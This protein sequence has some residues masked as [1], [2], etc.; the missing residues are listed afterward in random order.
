MSAVSPEQ[1]YA[2]GRALFQTTDFVE[3]YAGELL[4]YGA[5]ALPEGGSTAGNLAQRTTPKKK[6]GKGKSG[7]GDGG[8]STEMLPDPSGLL[9]LVDL[10][11]AIA[12][13]DA[14]DKPPP[15]PTLQPRL[16][17]TAGAGLTRAEASDAAADGIDGLRFVWG[18]FEVLKV[19]GV[20]ADPDLDAILAMLRR[21]RAGASAASPGAV[22]AIGLFGDRDRRSGPQDGWLAAMA[23]TVQAMAAVC[24][25]DRFGEAAALARELAIA[26]PRRADVLWACDGM[27]AAAEY[28]LDD[29]F[30]TDDGST[31]M[32]SLAEREILAEALR[33]AT[34]SPWGSVRRAALS[35]L[36][37]LPQPDF[38]PPKTTSVD[39]AIQG[40]TGPCDIVQRCLAVERVP[41]NLERSRDRRLEL[42]KLD[43]E[44]YCSQM[45]A[46]LEELPIRFLL[47]GFT[48][49]FTTLWTDVRRL[50]AVHAK[51]NPAMFWRLVIEWVRDVGQRLV[52]KFDAAGGGGTNSGAVPVLLDELSE[53]FYS[54][55]VAPADQD[56]VDFAKLHTVLF[57][58]L[59]DT[60][61][62]TEQHNRDII[63]L[64]LDFM[65]G[66]YN[67]VFEGFSES[68]DLT[69]PIETGVE[70]DPND[71]GS[72][73]AS[74]DDDDGSDD[75]D[76]AATEGAPGEKKQQKSIDN[77]GGQTVVRPCDGDGAVAMDSQPL[78]AGG[79][80]SAGLSKSERKLAAS[81][82]RKTVVGQLRDFLLLLSHF[83]NPA[84]VFRSTELEAVLRSMLM[85]SDQKS[86]VQLLALK[87]LLLYRHKYLTPY[88]DALQ[89][90]V[91]E[92]GN[93]REHLLTFSLDKDKGTGTVAPE[94]REP[95][96][97]VLSRIMIGKMMARKGKGKGQNNP[98]ARRRLILRFYSDCG[99]DELAAFFGLLFAPFRD[100]LDT[101][102][103]A[104]EAADITNAVPV[105]KQLGFL[106]LVV[107]IVSNLGTALEAYLPRV[108]AMALRCIHDADHM[109]A[110]RNLIAPSHVSVLR[111]IRLLGT[112]RVTDI[113]KSFPAFDFSRFQ[114]RVPPDVGF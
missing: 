42:D 70:V 106:N 108:F 22:E 41:A 29:G 8:R 113:V 67:V 56:H 94:H 98:K 95:L 27:L 51:A 90:I 78:A 104:A 66:E 87:C 60:A 10:V 44:H 55:A 9:F 76:Q 24:V 109:L 7:G 77:R 49:N 105:K 12:T 82:H 19:I 96:L 74:D 37:R 26:H 50:L 4:R 89:N 1:M 111:S 52:A 6:R 40:R 68:Q 114:V 11:D 83:K 85:R 28:E 62:L 72:A 97:E 79:A 103:A 18:A 13:S 64:F 32:G 88:G 31:I 69:A 112:K 81:F 45:P 15:P 99:P 84:Q 17:A 65:E 100:G 71:G 91:R 33:D 2:H 34:G 61:S 92:D 93:F 73:S 3:K 47:S 5:A 57:G 107:D 53:A 80:S 21:L 39:G 63:P 14:V 25:K 75:G 101:A 35:I 23:S 59:G 30:G 36:S 43:A 16:L 58:L 48:V 110:K 86:E 102:G 38:L 20:A 54:R 46:A